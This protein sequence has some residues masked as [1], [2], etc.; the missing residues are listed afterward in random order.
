LGNENVFFDVNTIGFG[1]DFERK[2]ITEIGMSDA[3]LIFIGD[4]WLEQRT[5]EPRG[6]RIWDLHDYVRKE[7]RE[8]LDRSILVI[9]ILVSGAQMP[10]PDQLPDDIRAITTKN[11]VLLRHESFDDDAENIVATIF[12]VSGRERYW[13]RLPSLWVRLFYAVAGS[14]ASSALLVLVALLHFS[15]LDRPLQL[16]IGAPMTVLMAVAMIVLG[17][18]FGMSYGIRRRLRGRARLETRKGSSV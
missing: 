8:A 16:S 14:L 15:L 17:A 1:D 2:I 7:V 10:H 3:A 11:A 9:P 6:G 13:E 5:P 18:W 4:R 12:G